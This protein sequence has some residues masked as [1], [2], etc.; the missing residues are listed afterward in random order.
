[1]RMECDG[2]YIFLLRSKAKKFETNV[3]ENVERHPNTDWCEQPKFSNMHALNFMRCLICLR[4]YPS[5]F[6]FGGT[7]RD[8]DLPTQKKTNQN[9]I[10]IWCRLYELV[11]I[12]CAQL[13]NE[14][15]IQMIQKKYHYLS[16]YLSLSLSL[17]WSPLAPI[18]SPLLHRLNIRS[19]RRV[20]F[21]IDNAEKHFGSKVDVAT[22]DIFTYEWMRRNKKKWRGIM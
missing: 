1:M 17:H 5:L 21:F 7:K 12:E 10:Y 18:R 2:Y 16:L 4:V 13:R 14:Y 20:S 8:E 3:V 6:D 11:S 19:H 22:R 15:Q 9:H